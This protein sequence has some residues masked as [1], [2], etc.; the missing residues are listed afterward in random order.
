MREIRLV[1]AHKEAYLPLLLVGDESERMIARYLSRGALYALF[2]DGQA[3]G[4]CVVTDEGGGTAEVQNL[5][6]QPGYERQGRGAYLL[7]E[8]LTRLRGRFARVRLGTGDAPGTLAFYRKQGFRET[9][10]V[11]GFFP[12]HYERP[13]VEDGVTLCDKVYLEK[14]L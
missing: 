12:A 7:G 5:A 1:S 9:G 3:R 8:V 11:P 4:V 14:N 6:V 10:R 13:I 2:E